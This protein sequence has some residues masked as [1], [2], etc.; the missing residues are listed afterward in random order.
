MD[1]EMTAP[2]N[3]WRFDPAR[4][5]WWARTGQY[6]WTETPGTFDDAPGFRPEAVTR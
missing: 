3:G 1:Q 5:V 4:E 2:V 6:T